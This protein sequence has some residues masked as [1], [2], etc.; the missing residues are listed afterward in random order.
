MKLRFEA[1]KIVN[2]EDHKVYDTTNKT[3]MQVL[4][5]DVNE[6]INELMFSLDDKEAMLERIEKVLQRERGYDD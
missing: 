3:D 5:N 6:F 1:G 2:Q 4:C